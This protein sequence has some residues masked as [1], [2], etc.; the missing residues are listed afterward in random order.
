M[1]WLGWNWTTY[2]LGCTSKELEVRF[3]GI[4]NLTS[5]TIVTIVEGLAIS[6]TLKPLWPCL[7]IIS[8]YLNCIA[9][10]QWTIATG[11]EYHRDFLWIEISRWCPSLQSGY[12]IHIRTKQNLPEMMAIQDWRSFRGYPGYFGTTRN[13]WKYEV[14]LPGMIH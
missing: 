14:F 2:Y 3:H 6:Q 10:T 11:C 13:T 9:N 5:L 4:Y 8:T 12:M 7:L 1:I